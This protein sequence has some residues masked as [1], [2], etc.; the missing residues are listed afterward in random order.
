MILSIAIDLKLTSG[1]L[2]SPNLL[3]RILLWLWLLFKWSLGVCSIRN[4]GKKWVVS[5]MY[6]MICAVKHSKTP[7]KAR[8]HD[9]Y[10]HFM[11]FTM[12]AS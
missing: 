5:I 8:I 3:V 1:A 6:H 10:R 7:A 4:S 2:V 9:P 12:V 11:A